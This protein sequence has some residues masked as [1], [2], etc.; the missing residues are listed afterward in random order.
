MN[1]IEEE[2]YELILEKGLSSSTVRTIRKGLEQLSPVFLTDVIAEN[3]NIY[4]NLD[5]LIEFLPYIWDDNNNSSKNLL[6]YISGISHRLFYLAREYPLGKKIPEYLQKEL[7]DIH[8]GLHKFKEEC[9]HE[10]IGDSSSSI[11]NLNSYED[12]V[13]FLEKYPRFPTKLYEMF[14]IIA[15]LYHQ[16]T[17]NHNQKFRNI[18]ELVIYLSRCLILWRLQALTDKELINC[19]EFSQLK[20]KEEINIIE[21]EE[22]LALELQNYQFLQLGIDRFLVEII[23]QFMEKMREK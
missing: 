5:T 18:D 15:S 13:D 4:T 22:N 16:F 14:E 10:D 3:V 19:L 2:I 21:F 6:N 17:Q 20:Y 9:I 8:V 7:E 23:T 1:K 12:L 11:D